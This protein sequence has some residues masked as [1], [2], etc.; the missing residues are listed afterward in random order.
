MVAV[1]FVLQAGATGAVKA[2]KMSAKFLVGQGSTELPVAGEV[3][4]SMAP[5]TGRPVK[6]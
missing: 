2:V 4:P 6:P 3:P 1:G 5:D